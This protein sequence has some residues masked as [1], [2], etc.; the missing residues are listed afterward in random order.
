MGAV[1]IPQGAGPICEWV[2]FHNFIYFIALHTVIIFMLKTKLHITV[3]VT[4]IEL[5]EVLLCSQ[6]QLYLR[7][8]QTSKL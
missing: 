5:N 1:R 6:N 3:A 8:V 7:T 2:G 4:F